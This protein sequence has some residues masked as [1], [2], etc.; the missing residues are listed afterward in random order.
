[1]TVPAL[2]L[3]WL[4]GF[5]AIAVWGAPVWMAAAWIT[6]LLPAAAY[7]W[8]RYG[9]AVCALA[10]LLSLGGSLRFEH[11]LDHPTSPL[12]TLTGARVTITG[13]VDG[14]PDPGLTTV[15]YPVLVLE[16]FTDDGRVVRDSGRVLITVNQY[17]EL[18]PGGHVRLT[19]K[20]EQP[21]SFSEFDY[22]AWLSRQGIVGTM[23]FPRVHL[24]EGHNLTLGRVTTRARLSLEQALQRSLPEPEA[25][26][27]AGIAFGRD[28]NFSPA[29]KDDFRDAGLAHVVAVSG[30]NVSVVAAV[31]FLAFVPILG[32]NRAIFPALI[33][34]G[35][36]VA[37]AGFTASVVRAG[38]MAFVFLA[39]P[40][41][42][43][44]QTG[45][46][47]LGL[48]AVL[49]TLHRP[50]IVMDVG[51]QLSFAATAG[52][53]AFNPWVQRGLEWVVAKL[54]ATAVVPSLGLQALSLTLSATAATA[55]II[56]IAFGRVSLVSLVTNLVVEPLFV[57]VLPLSLATGLAGAAWE[58]AGWA[59]GL[60]AYYPLTFVVWVAE[61]AAGLPGAA[62]TT[63]TVSPT[64][65]A[66]VYAVL[67][68]AGFAAYR[69][70]APAFAVRLSRAR[71][72]SERRL[73][74]AG[75]FGAIAL[76]AIPLS[77]E[78]MRDPAELRIDF[79]DVGQGD[80][81]LI[82][83]PGGRRLLID[84][85]ASGIGLARELGHV[86]P[87]W[88]RR[89]DRVVLTHPQEDHVA[90]FPEL[91]RRFNVGSA[92][93][94][95]KDGTTIAARLFDAAGPPAEALVAGDRWKIDGVEFEVL[96][97]PP[98]YANRQ[99]NNASVVLRVSYRERVFL[100]TGDIEAAA[101]ADLVASQDVR[102]D[103]LKV[104]HHGSKTTAPEFLSRVA[105]AVAVISV[106]AANRFGHPA[107]S[108]L[109][110]L[111]G[112]RLFRTD[113]DGR[114][115]VRTRG[116]ELRVSTAKRLHR[117]RCE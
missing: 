80:A 99:V 101:Q 106:G 57:V 51:F 22:R 112:S 66:A 3:A 85:G 47:A 46:P 84:S 96:W 10:A 52:L 89:I 6:L 88:E 15:R 26:L 12:A 71:R 48:A 113:C 63:P 21:E 82:T 24:L 91:F 117:G 105:P 34:V 31:I 92:R 42:G 18:L 11:W 68:I 60:V 108:T 115:T 45:M 59:A 97:P 114:V 39:A 111:A 16:A 53:I 17:T 72:Q 1:M 44:Q 90:G 104:P 110:A 70:H 20:L 98:G 2:A 55:P 4:L 62:F 13:V 25:S 77:L 7:R 35:S 86:L 73:I 87:H 32:R 74:A 64:T 54:H 116:A 107:E 102:A 79:L 95:G 33:M 49:M 81:T 27:A 40:L 9:A 75:A 69:R 67:G 78:A 5:A 38:I 8:G 76:A 103:L 65:G 37:L 29:L 58:P 93:D 19:G 109:G 36:Y 41:F 94:N 23:A 43:R 28:Q 14:E 56:C 30:A 83:T 100:F 61:T 50:A